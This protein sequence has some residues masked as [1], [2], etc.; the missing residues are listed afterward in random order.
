LPTGPKRPRSTV[1]EGTREST[2]PPLIIA[3]RTPSGH[4][5]TIAQTTAPSR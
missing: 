2:I 3:S 4:T 1:L 5:I